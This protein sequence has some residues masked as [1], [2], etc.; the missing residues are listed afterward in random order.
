[1]DNVIE[2]L[3]SRVAASSVRDDLSVINELEE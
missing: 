3:E 2:E 1:M